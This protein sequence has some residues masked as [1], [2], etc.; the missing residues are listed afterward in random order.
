MPEIPMV[1]DIKW[2]GGMI[3]VNLHYHLKVVVLK[4]P[5]AMTV[6][7]AYGDSPNHK[8]ISLLLYKCKV[9]AVVN[10]NINI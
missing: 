8:I 7:H 3:T 9:A 6:L 4:L 1:S 5:D 10:H 2:E